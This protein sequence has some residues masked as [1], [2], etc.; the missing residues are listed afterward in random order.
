[1]ITSV[2]RETKSENRSGYGFDLIVTFKYNVCFPALAIS[3]AMGGVGIR[4]VK[5][6][7]SKKSKMEYVVS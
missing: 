6:N 4:H 7:M 5:D 3:K 2:Y 1:M